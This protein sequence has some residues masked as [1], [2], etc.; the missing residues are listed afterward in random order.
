MIDG[1]YIQPLQILR[2]GI[3]IRKRLEVNDELMRVET[4]SNVRDAFFDLLPDGIGLDRRW[5]AEGVVVTVGATADGDRS[6]AVGTGESAV[7]DHFVN[8]L[9]ELLL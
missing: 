2:F 6:V 8:A 9:A 4:F 1:I 5:R 3:S 7:D